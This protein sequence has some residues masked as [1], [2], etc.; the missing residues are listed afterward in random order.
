MPDLC[1]TLHF[2]V[3]EY[4]LNHRGH[5]VILVFGQA[6]TENDLC[7][8]CGKGAILVCQFGVGGVIHRVE[9][10]AALRPFGGE[11]LGDDGAGIS[12]N[13]RPDSR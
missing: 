6:A 12:I 13:L 11:F 2:R 3:V 8:L 10:L 4:L 7:F 1:P 9:R 5:V